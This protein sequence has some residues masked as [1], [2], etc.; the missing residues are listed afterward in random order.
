MSNHELQGDDPNN[1]ASTPASG[2]NR[3]SMVTNQ[4]FVLNMADP[5]RRVTFTDLDLLVAVK[6]KPLN[7]DGYDLKMDLHRL[8]VSYRNRLVKMRLPAK[9]HASYDRSPLAFKP[10]QPLPKIDFCED[11]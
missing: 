9:T 8:P 5:L 3:D 10:A 4:T 11:N 6:P 2:V 1:I 7:L